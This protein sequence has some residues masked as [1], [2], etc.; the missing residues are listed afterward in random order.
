MYGAGLH[1]ED[2]KKKMW[3]TDN[4]QDVTEPFV[5]SLVSLF[6]VVQAL[7][8]YDSTSDTEEL[9]YICFVCVC[10]RARV[11]YYNVYDSIYYQVKLLPQDKLLS[12]PI[13]IFLIIGANNCLLYSQ[14][15]FTLKIRIIFLKRFTELQFLTF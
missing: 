2:S 15:C 7:Q 14:K 11:W 13:I 10:A 8:N 6:C 3:T 4:E 9:S 1:V 12:R 5:I